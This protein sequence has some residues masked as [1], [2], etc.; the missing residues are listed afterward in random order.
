MS[1]ESVVLSIF[2]RGGSRVDY[3]H[4]RSEAQAAIEAWVKLKKDQQLTNKITF[5]STYDL[6]YSLEEVMA[7]AIYEPTGKSAQERIAEVM[8]RQLGDGEEWRN[9]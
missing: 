8:E 1:D 5:S 2:L 9:G 3:R 4:S 6:A 7:L